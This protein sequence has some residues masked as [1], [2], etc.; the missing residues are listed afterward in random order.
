MAKKIGLALSGGGSKGAFIVGALSAIRQ[1]VG[2]RFSVISGT[3]TGSLIA[4]LLAT[5]QWTR[6]VK[7]YTTVKTDNIVSPNLPLVASLAGPEAVL[8]ASAILGGRAIFD[9]K[10]LSDMIDAHVDFERVKQAFPKTMVIFNA[11][12]MQTGELAM[13]NNRDHGPDLLKK[14][15]LASANMPVLTDPVQIE[16]D[17]Q[18]H[19]YVDGGLREFLPLAAVFG[20]G[21]EIDH[22]YAISSSPLRA[23]KGKPEYDRITDI[24]GRTVD[25]L[26]AEVGYNDFQTGLMGNALLQMRDN[27]RA[28]GVAERELFAGVDPS[29]RKWLKGKRVVPI[30]FI[31]PDKHIDMDSLTFDPESMQKLKDQGE[32]TAM[33]ILRKAAGGARATKQATE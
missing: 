12:D 23:K 8:F 20:S 10:G 17:G 33:R 6:L 9:T 3:S 16:V 21:V 14:G 19:Q 2:R 4:S 26:S 22:I 11:V 5:N 28:K 1:T 7:I 24:L 18:T 13:F 15:L 27:A 25:L 31:G 30:T 32:N 29:I